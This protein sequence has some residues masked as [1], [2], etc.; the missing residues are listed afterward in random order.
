MA[1][2]FLFFALLWAVLEWRN[3]KACERTID[4]LLNQVAN[5]EERLG[6]DERTQAE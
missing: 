3:R 4:A 2:F 5:L 6:M 1:W